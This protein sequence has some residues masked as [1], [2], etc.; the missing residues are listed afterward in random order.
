V[1]E[2]RAFH[3]VRYNERF[4]DAIGL[5]LAPPYDVLSPHLIERL[6][7]RHPDNMVH[8]EHIEPEP[9]ED[10]HQHAAH[11]YREWRKRGILAR[12]N[13]SAFYRYDH[14]FTANEQ[15]L[16]R[17]GILAAVRLAHWSERRVLPHEATFPQPRIE[18]LRRLRAVRANLSPLYL[19]TRDPHGRF[20]D[21]L[22]M[23]SERPPDVVGVDPDGEEHR[24][25]LLTDPQTRTRL[26]AILADQPLYVADGHHRYE[27]ALAYRD[28][29]RAMSGQAH[30][31]DP[32]GPAAF[33]Y[34]MALVCAAD[35]PGVLVLPTHLL[36]FDLP[37]FEPEAIRRAMQGFFELEH[38]PVD[39]IDDAAVAD[40]VTEGRTI[41]L[42]QFAGED[43][44]WRVRR[45]QTDPHEALMPNDH[46]PVWRRLSVAIVGSAIIE[47]VLG[48]AADRRPL[49]V[50]YAHD[51]AT[52]RDGLAE[53]RAQIAFFLPASSVDELMAVADAGEIMPPK[54]TYFWPKVPAGLA[55]HD[56]A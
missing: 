48:I 21:A 47:G 37:A 16:T 36:V 25:T 51:A 11:L 3:G 8:L 4:N 34:V 18:R 5:L 55:I 40:L 56:L 27:A 6:R 43:G 24:L 26:G 44:L 2:V 53:K 1:T 10:P 38:L 39:G 31:A 54:S 46:N 14:T 15:R 35:D 45:R 9:G 20:R 52:A 23:A 19:L 29:R 7:E 17:T 32:D 41:C 49:H 42:A 33:E 30:E 50:A 13:Q 22:A 28:E 12:D